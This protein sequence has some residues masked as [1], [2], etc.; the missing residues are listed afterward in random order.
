MTS[1]R[2]WF[3][4]TLDVISGMAPRP[5]TPVNG[6]SALRRALS[7]P[8]SPSR[9]TVTP[10]GG[11]PTSLQRLPS[12]D[13]LD[14]SIHNDSGHG[15]SSAQIIRDL[16]QSNARLTAQTAAMEADFMNQLEVFTRQ[17]KEA[18]EKSGLSE[19]HVLTLET[20]CKHS[21]LRLK[22]KDEQLQKLR[23]ESAFHRHTISEL[24]SQNLQPEKMEQ[25]IVSLQKELIRERDERA[26]AENQLIRAQR[27]L[28][29]TG[30]DKKDDE[31]SAPWNQLERTQDAL[32]RTESAL[33]DLQ[34]E[35]K[36]VQSEHSKTVSRM[37]SELKEAQNEYQRK[38]ATLS[39]KIQRLEQRDLAGDLESQ[40]LERDEQIDNLR[41]EVL[42]YSSQLTELTKDLSRVKAN[43]ET[44][45]QYRREE[46]DDLRVLSDA[47]EEELESLRKQLEEALQ[48]IEM[49]DQELAER[50]D[51]LVLEESSR[52]L[53]QLQDDLE[54][55][56]QTIDRLEHQIAEIKMEHADKVVMYEET[57]QNLVEA[58]DYRDSDDDSASK[59]L[60]GEIDRS[61]L[62]EMM[63]KVKKLE[64]EVSNTEQQLADAR[65][66]L[67]CADEN[68]KQLALEYEEK[69]ADAC[70][71]KDDIESGH[72][73][74]LAVMEA[75]LAGLRQD[76]GSSPAGESTRG[77]TTFVPN[78]NR[79]S[80]GSVEEDLRKELDDVKQS[81]E[82]LRA[83]IH[84]LE[85]GWQS[86]LDSLQEKLDD[87]DTTISA[88]V[89]SSVTLEQ[90]LASSKIEIDALRRKAHVGADEAGYDVI[91]S[92]SASVG[93]AEEVKA[94]LE[95][96][97]ELER[98]LSQ[99]NSH[100]KKLLHNAKADMTRLRTRMEAYKAETIVLRSQVDDDGAS[101]AG[102]SN[103]S[104][105]PQM[106]IHERDIAIA[107]LVQQ[108]IEQDQLISELQGKVTSMSGELESLRSF[109]GCEHN[110]PSWDEV[111]ELRKETEM[112]AGQVIEQDEEIESLNKTIIAQDQQ[113]AGLREELLKLRLNVEQAQKIVLQEPEPVS[114]RTIEEEEADKKQIGRLKA[115][116]D[117]LE[118]SNA[119]LR[120]EIRLLR[121]KS[122]DVEVSAM[123][124]DRMKEELQDAKKDAREFEIMMEDL[125]TERSQLLREIDELRSKSKEVSERLQ[126]VEVDTAGTIRSLESQLSERQDEVDD[127]RAAAAPNI[128]TKVDLAEMEDLKNEIDSLRR[129]M[130]HQAAALDSARQTIRELERMLAEHNEQHA[131]AWEEERDE[132]IL[133][134]ESL[135]Q[136]LTQA[137]EELKE[138]EEQRGI[139]EDFKSKLE[140]ADE[141]REVSEQNIV[142][143]YER[144]LSLLKLD[145]DVT[146][147]KLRNELSE[148]K[149]SSCEEI[150]ALRLELEQYEIGVK[151]LREQMAIEM[152]VRETRIF[153]LE[154][155]LE[156]QEQLVNNMKTEMDHLQGSMEN[157]AVARR[158]EIEDMQQELV[159]LTSMVAQQDR[160]IKSLQGLLQDRKI[161]YESEVSKLKETVA[162]LD[163]ENSEDHRSAAD[164][165]MELRLREVKDRLEKLKWRNSSLS[166]E[167]EGLRERLQKAEAQRAAGTVDQGRLGELQMELEGQHIKVKSLED[168]ILELRSTTVPKSVM[169]P[170]PRSSRKASQPS[171]SRRLGF[172][173]RKRANS[174]DPTSDE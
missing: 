66:M 6:P 165:Q 107:N 65:S 42:E 75:E 30:D 9:A 162:I 108:S 35:Q 133:E 59:R 26:R 94:S 52:A 13:S 134:I 51:T 171:P 145:K 34:H 97:K 45:E 125:S 63:A 166:E 132:L 41:Q 27:L 122:R 31:E 104:S 18:Q 149:E 74:V 3:E 160:E 92:E 155:T 23:E 111:K 4:G 141:A 164:L 144:K 148:L 102:S 112:F 29:M 60:E 127:V 11:G 172:L 73:D 43:A 174:Q 154:H 136:K 159:D 157:R 46:A 89:K 99:E 5:S 167:N 168:E 137:S 17:L 88:L 123:E 163:K 20:R 139:I 68:K 143:T 117:E 57:V 131:V 81:E 50:N 36:R 33:V 124:I 24:R 169:P 91:L 129:E 118:E 37:E 25:D 55:A 15:K 47:Q 22:E 12:Q 84:E 158:E 44:Q 2:G 105:S 130:S 150:E 135:T 71:E 95:R 19:K 121:R 114:T 28:H 103:V 100:L 39:G 87:R 146:I 161:Q 106:Q 32:F 119:V 170:T 8:S 113:I 78:H 86:Q 93:E 38:Q 120:D 64:S 53:A 110:G 116:I 156:A 151:E 72:H 96:Y 83:K 79:Q 16:R 7:A 56:R 173:G 14:R 90:Q 152:Q 142:D 70:R 54:D 98:Q 10:Q 58:R 101:Y 77:E 85:R 69:L 126:K 128:N 48:E 115:E 147:D 61:L 138:I 40:L 140:E 153:A 1:G 49:R 67:A 109:Q 80:G 76:A 21:E 82:S 62:H